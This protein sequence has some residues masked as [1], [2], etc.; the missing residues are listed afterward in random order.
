M[1]ANLARGAYSALGAAGR[2][3]CSGVSARR[4]PSCAGA[5]RSPSP[6][7]PAS[8]TSCRRSGA[9][10]LPERSRGAAWAGFGNLEV[11]LAAK[12]SRSA[13]RE[14]ACGSRSSTKRWRRFRPAGGSVA[15]RCRRLRRALRQPPGPRP[16][17]AAAEEAL[18]RARPKVVGTY[19]LLRGEV[20]E[21]HA[22]FYSEG[23]YE[24]GADPGGKGHR[25]LLELG[26]S[27]VLKP[28]R[29]KRTVELLWQGIYA[30]VL[31]PPDRRAD[32]LR[33]PGRHGS[34]PAGPAA[35]VPAPPCPRP[36]A[37]RARALPERAVA[38]DRLPRE[39]VDPKAARCRRCRR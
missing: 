29:S 34:G 9:I 5:T 33:Q 7:R 36:E 18:R 4:S 21:R 38:M 1:V 12:K 17:R 14:R 19:R 24:P 28:Y 31:H 32:R 22:G 37:W 26:R 30:Y 3:A 2:R 6:G 11:R 23:E 15:T 39:A 8:P 35:L 13:A 25:R 16:C 10:R 20:A 27:C